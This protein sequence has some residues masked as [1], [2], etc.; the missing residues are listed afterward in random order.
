[1]KFI[2]LP[3]AGAFVIELEKRGDER[4]F[5]ARSFCEQEFAA[6]GLPTVFVQG[7]VSFSA[8]RGTLRGMH[9]QVAEHG[10]DKLVR[11]TRGAIHDVIVDLRPESPTYGRWAGVDLSAE[12]GRS[13][14]VPR[15]FAHGFIT[16]QDATEVSYLMSAAYA[17]GSDGGVRWDDPAI[18]IEWPIAPTVIAD[19]DRVWPD[20]AQARPVD[21]P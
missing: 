17:P 15:R 10:E 19:K 4:G 3:L 11:V 7:N 6:H 18:G 8:Q 5:F 16:L 20:L 13:L 9:Y 1:M 14:L 2:E 12:T 21:G